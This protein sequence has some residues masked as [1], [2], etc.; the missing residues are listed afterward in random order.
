M[1]VRVKVQ[2]EFDAR[3][4]AEIF[5]DFEEEV[6][7]SNITTADLKAVP[8]LPGIV[9]DPTLFKKVSVNERTIIV[10][11][12]EAMDVE[13]ID[14]FDEL[15]DDEWKTD[16]PLPKRKKRKKH[17]ETVATPKEEVVARKKSRKKLDKANVKSRKKN[18]KKKAEGGHWK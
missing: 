12:S 5:L 9:S 16:L 17:N 1:T 7:P 6:D 10:P 18:R 11:F 15:I 4:T 3:I 14:P 13:D 8:G 2:Y